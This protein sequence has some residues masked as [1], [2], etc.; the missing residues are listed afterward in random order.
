LAW[1]RALRRKDLEDPEKLKS[2]LKNAR[3]CRKHFVSKFSADLRQQS[4]VDW[5]PTLEMGAPEVAVP[6]RIAKAAVNRAV[7]V[8]KRLAKQVIKNHGFIFRTV[9]HISIL[10]SYR[11]YWKQQ[12]QPWY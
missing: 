3:I 6:L 11:M 7:R 8:E 10:L 2:F 9:S 4:N 5:I 1:I 12:F